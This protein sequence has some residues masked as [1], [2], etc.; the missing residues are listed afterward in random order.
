MT[1]PRTCLYCPNDTWAKS[2]ICKACRGDGQKEER[3]K[4]RRRRRLSDVEMQLKNDE[5]GWPYEDREPPPMEVT[6]FE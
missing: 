1:G 4:K 3:P 5:D 6:E 2:Q